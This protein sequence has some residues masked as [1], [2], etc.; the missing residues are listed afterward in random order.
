ML[1]VLLEASD[2]KHG[3]LALLVYAA[4][5]R[6]VGSRQSLRPPAAALAALIPPADQQAPFQRLSLLLQVRWSSADSH[7]LST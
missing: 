7:L 1:Q 4:L 3:P 6:G 5:A 2:G